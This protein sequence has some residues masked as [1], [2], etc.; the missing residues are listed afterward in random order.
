MLRSSLI[1]GS[2]GSYV[3]PIFHLFL[4]GGRL[5]NLGLR[6]CQSHNVKIMR[7]TTV[8]PVIFLSI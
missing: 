5:A 7:L 1:S 6:V 2:T 8:S 4:S 3:N